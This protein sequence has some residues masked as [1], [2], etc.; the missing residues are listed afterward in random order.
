MYGVYGIYK[1]EYTLRAGHRSIK[2]AYFRTLVEKSN[3]PESLVQLV[4]QAQFQPLRIRILELLQAFSSTSSAH[5]LD[6]VL[7]AFGFSLRLSLIK[8]ALYS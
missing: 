8:I 7:A 3:L 5:W 6:T 2:Q 1:Y 4:E